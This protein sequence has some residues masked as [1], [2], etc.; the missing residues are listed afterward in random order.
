MAGNDTLDG[1]NGNDVLDGGGGNDTLTGGNG[2][3]MLF[4]SVGNDTLMGGKG[5][6]T[7]DGGAGNDDLMAARQGPRSVRFQL[8]VSATI[9]SPTSATGTTSSLTMKCSQSPQAVLDASQQV[10]EDTVI[11]A[12]TNTVTL[13]G[14]QASSLQADD[15]LI[16]A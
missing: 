1:G 16:L 13:L 8:L 9:S 2:N 6:D 10:G 15:F 14:V 3:D 7:L 11:T 12:G 5:E 4:G